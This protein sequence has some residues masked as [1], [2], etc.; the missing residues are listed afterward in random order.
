MPLGRLPKKSNFL[1]IR[2]AQIEAVRLWNAVKSIRTK[3]ESR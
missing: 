3:K 2:E 1:G